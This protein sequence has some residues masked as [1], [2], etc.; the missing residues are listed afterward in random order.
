MEYNSYIYAHLKR[1]VDEALKDKN[2]T[3]LKIEY[4][5]I[6][7]T[8]VEAG[9]NI[10][11]AYYPITPKTDDVVT[12]AAYIKITNK[13]M[14]TIKN[15]VKIDII[16]PWNRVCNISATYSFDPRVSVSNPVN[17]EPGIPPGGLNR[18]S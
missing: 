9:S 2:L 1:Q 15:P 11:I 16:I 8:T 14:M 17:A 5:G 18:E 13:S 6:N 10:T 7:E 4:E 3:K 12:H